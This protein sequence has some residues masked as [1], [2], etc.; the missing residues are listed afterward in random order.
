MMTEII[1]EKTKEDINDRSE[2]D[3]LNEEESNL[4]KNK[5]IHE[6]RDN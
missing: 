2:N 4:N 1:K 6:I 5:I 3:S